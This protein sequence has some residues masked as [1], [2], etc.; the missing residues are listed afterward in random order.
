MNPFSAV[1]LFSSSSI[2]SLLQSP[3]CPP[4]LHILLSPSPLSM[5]LPSIFLHSLAFALPPSFSLSLSLFLCPVKGQTVTGILRTPLSSAQTRLHLT[6]A[7]CD[8]LCF[9]SCKKTQL[10]LLL[11]VIISV[12]IVFKTKL[13]WSLANFIFF[14]LN[15]LITSQKCQTATRDRDR[16]LYNK[17]LGLAVH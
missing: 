5:S 10:F 13:Q 9:N 6:V 16:H 4:S 12:F 7:L 14:C 2:F 11:C 3:L 8:H 17:H 15:Y 1:S